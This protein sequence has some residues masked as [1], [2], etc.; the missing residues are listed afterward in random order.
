MVDHHRTTGTARRARFDVVLLDG[1]AR[2]TVIE[3]ARVLEQ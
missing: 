1:G 3:N 2:P